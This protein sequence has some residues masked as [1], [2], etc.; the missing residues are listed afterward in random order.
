MTII[1]T[2]AFLSTN[3]FIVEGASMYSAEEIVE[4]SGLSVG[5]N[6]FF[7]NSQS[8]T[9]SIREALPFINSVH[10]S[11]K[12]PDTVRIEVTESIAVAYI[13]FAGDHYIIDSTGRVLERSSGLENSQSMMTSEGLI[14][15]RG[16]EI[17]E[18]DVGNTLRPVFGTETK[19]QY[20]QDV[21]TGMEREEIINDVSYL[22]VSNIVN[23]NFG[24]L[25]LY[26]VI[27][28]GSTNLR[29]SNI[30]HNL[31]ILSDTVAQIV[32]YFP[33]TVGD[34]DMTDESGPPKFTPRQ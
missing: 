6:L 8:A 12:L 18:T 10:I 17:E 28:G 4:A 24:Y 29:P 30:R 27:L 23:V 11:R 13:L 16:A 32:P 3:G 25:G 5:D 14:E 33:N 20:I 19:L 15:I 21:L 7:V 2:S 1:G 9:Q 26:K 22:D 34:I 31:S